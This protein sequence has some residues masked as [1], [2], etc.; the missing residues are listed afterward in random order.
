M[1]DSCPTVLRRVS[2]QLHLN[3]TEESKISGMGWV[4]VW[5]WQKLQCLVFSGWYKCK[6]TELG[7]HCDVDCV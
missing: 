2:K 4:R 3:E 6:V 7:M 1:I 5:G